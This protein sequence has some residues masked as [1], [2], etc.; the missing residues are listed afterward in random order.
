MAALGVSRLA[1]R[2]AIRRGTKL[3]ATIGPASSQKETLTRMIESGGT[4][5]SGTET[6]DR[7]RGREHRA[8]VRM[9]RAR[10]RTTRARARARARGRRGR[11]RG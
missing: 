6:P 9:A 4:L 8:L 3:V 11:G 7:R 2:S 10:T 5:A 1:V